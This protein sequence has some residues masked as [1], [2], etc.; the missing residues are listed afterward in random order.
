MPPSHSS[1][2]STRDGEGHDQPL[3]TVYRRCVLPLFAE[4]L[5]RGELKLAHVLDRAR[6]RRIGEEEIRRFDPDGSSFFNMNTPVDYAE[7]L[8]RWRRR[9]TKG[10]A[11]ETP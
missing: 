11:T 3:H 2:R 5:A 6:T 10:E 8:G 4:Q 7:A 9:K 1:T